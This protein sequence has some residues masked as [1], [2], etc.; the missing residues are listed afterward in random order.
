MRDGSYFVFTAQDNTSGNT[1]LPYGQLWAIDERSTLFKRG[2]T[3]PVQL[4]S[5]P[6]RWLQAVSGKGSESLFADGMV[7]R[8]ELMR[9]DPR[10]AELRPFLH[11]ISA[12]FLEYSPDGN[13]M[14]YVSFPE[15][16]LWR[17]NRDGSSPVQ[18]TSRPV[19]PI[20]PRWSPDGSRILYFT[21]SYGERRKAFIVPAQGGE[22]VQI[23]SLNHPTDILDPTWSPD[24][25][26]VVYSTAGQENSPT[27][28]VE[29]LDLASHQSAKIKGS[30]GMWSPRWSPD[31]HYVAA[32]DPISSV[33]IFDF[34]TEKWTTLAKGYCGEPTWS[35]DSRSIYY[36]RGTEPGIFRVPL[37]GGGPE[38]AFDL[39]ASSMTGA[40]GGW[41][42][43][44]PDGMPM[45]LRD[46]GS[47]EIYLLKLSK[48]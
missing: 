36:N 22:S 39:P 16:V 38:K 17:A 47:D 10:S 26:K 29:I 9:Y 27:D 41:F 18:L 35:H 32:L 48:E 6:L 4:T 23:S 46:A 37:K 45:M 7:F 20:N 3:S 19:Y 25:R 40:L 24:G 21:M 2:A 33:M 43:M 15:G 1:P 14:V 11:G 42:G 28:D 34:E 30:K 12:E 13:A 5:G 8:G 31:G 44:D